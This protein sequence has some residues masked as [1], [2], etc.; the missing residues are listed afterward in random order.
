MHPVDRLAQQRLAQRPDERDA[1]GHR[2]LEEQVDAGGLGRGE[3]LGADVGEQLL[4]GGDHRLAR[5]ERVEDQLAGGLDA[6]DDLDHDVDVGVGHDRGGVVGEDVG[7]RRTRRS[8]EAL[9][10][11][12]RATSSRSPVRASMSSAASSISWTRAA[13]TL[14]H[15]S[16][17]T[18]TGR[19]GHVPRPLRSRAVGALPSGPPSRPSEPSPLGPP[20]AAPC[21]VGGRT[22]STASTGGR[23][24]SA[25]VRRSIQLAGRRPVPS[26]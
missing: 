8:C 15:P 19:H 4:V 21:H 6:A 3:E 24:R 23:R 26:P 2:R 18:V 7:A 17:P 9:R 1:A 16:R 22:V 5:L 14:P 20:V 12:T 10:T 11:A 13:P 25:A